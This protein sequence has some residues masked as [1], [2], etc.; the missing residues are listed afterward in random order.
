MDP[1]T[2]WS[3]CCFSLISNLPIYPLWGKTEK[4]LPIFQDKKFIES[5][6]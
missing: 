5:K 4:A 2:K 1:Y 6:K 3:K